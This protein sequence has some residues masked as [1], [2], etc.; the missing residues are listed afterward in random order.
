MA[1]SHSPQIVRDGLVLYLDAANIKS[2]PGSGTIAFDLSNKNNN[3]TLINGVGYDNANLG[4]LVFDGIND[5]VQTP[6]SIGA[7][8]TGNFTFGVWA[9]RLGNSTTAIGGLVG[10][11]WH[12]SFTGASIYFLNNNTSVVV[13]T[14][15]GTTRTSYTLTNPVSNLNW[16]NYVLINNAGMV[17]VYVNGILIDSRVRNISPS[18][19]RPITIGRWAGSYLSEYVLNGKIS[20]T[21]VYNKALTEA[22]VKQN[23]EALRGRYGI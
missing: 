2:Y 13:Q 17:S 23:F 1:L 20:N 18:S 22:E 10:N 16:A 9:I 11:L 12:T 6:T 4:S 8:L 7:D 19:T 15:D 14:A 5:Y 3:G 21:Q